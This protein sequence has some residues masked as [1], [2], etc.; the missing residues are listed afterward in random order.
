MKQEI[1]SFTGFKIHPGHGKRMVK[2][3]GRLVY[4]ISN[5]A[6]VHYLKKKNPRKVDWTAIYRRVNR[7]GV[8][9]DTKKKAKRRVVKVTRGIVGASVEDIRRKKAAREEIRSASK[10]AAAKEAADRKAKRVSAKQKAVK[11]KGGA[12]QK[13]AAK[14]VASKGR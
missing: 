14:K 9:K 13:V 10:T 6:F 4:F 11:G 3:D 12:T 8:S 1:C 7:K 5:K 2:S